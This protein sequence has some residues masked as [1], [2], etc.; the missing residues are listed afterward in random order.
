MRCAALR[1]SNAKWYVRINLMD[2]FA[3]CFIA[4]SSTVSHLCDGDDDDEFETSSSRVFA[5]RCAVLRVALR[6]VASR[7]HIAHIAFGGAARHGAAQS[8][9]AHRPPPPHFRDILIAS[10]RVASRRVASTAT[11]TARAVQLEHSS[12]GAMC[13]RRRLSATD[14]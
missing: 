7:S 2:S 9:A 11:A 14:S 12:I 13:A 1:T 4:L 6:R 10:F 3:R 8:H 5:L